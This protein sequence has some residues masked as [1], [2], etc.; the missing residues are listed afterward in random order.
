MNKLKYLLIFFLII[1]SSCSKEKEIS[2]IK[3]TNQDLEMITAYK[4]GLQGL[5][6]ND[7]YYAAKKFLEAELLYPQSE[8]A[9]TSALMASYAYYLQN[10]YSKALLNL[11][12]FL[13]TYPNNRNID[14]AHYLIAMIY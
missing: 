4:E 11:E 5:E 7:F 8:W 9:S 10:F 1:L 3:E 2:L 14:Y 12:R 13:K 6:D